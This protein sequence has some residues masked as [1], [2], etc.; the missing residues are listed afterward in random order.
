M[1]SA[2]LTDRYRT[3]LKRKQASLPADMPEEEKR[4]VL[5]RFLAAMKQADRTAVKSSTLRTVSG[6]QKKKYELV[7]AY[8]TERDEQDARA[9]GKSLQGA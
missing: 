7:S 6:L 2:Y 3:F 9:L 5:E 8:L 1:D 4:Q